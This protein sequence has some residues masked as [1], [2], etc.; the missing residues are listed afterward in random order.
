MKRLTLTLAALLIAFS[1][2]G[3]DDAP[4]GARLMRDSGDQFL[5]AK[6]Y[7]DALDA[8][9]QALSTHPRYSEVHY[10]LGVVFLKG[11][12][13]YDLARYHFQTCLSLAPDREDSL[14]VQALVETLAD[15]GREA[16][17]QRERYPLLLGG[18]C[19]DRTEGAPIAARDEVD[20]DIPSLGR[21]RLIADYVYPNG[22]VLTN[23]FPEAEA[24]PP[25][26][27][28]S[29]HKKP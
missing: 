3:E 29:A 2:A 17:A 10:K 6:R 16:E 22:L 15:R 14:D 27:T 11:Y 8:Y 13:A 7:A 25:D 21:R 20:I 19:L 23:R 26:A 9:F 12:R 1:A 18:R 24:G 4:R 5:A 28:A